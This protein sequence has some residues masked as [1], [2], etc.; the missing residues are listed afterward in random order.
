M[1]PRRCD[2]VDAAAQESRTEQLAYKHSRAK[3]GR[4]DFARLSCRSCCLSIDLAY[5][6]VFSNY[7]KSQPIQ[8]SRSGRYT[9]LSNKLCQAIQIC[10]SDFEL[11]KYAPP[12]GLLNDRRQH[13]EPP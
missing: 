5:A 10:Y 9:E 8:H 3:H 13:A 11:N 2:G 1:R 4:A 6:A 7:S 12:A